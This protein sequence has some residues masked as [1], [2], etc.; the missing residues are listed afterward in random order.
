MSEKQRRLSR[1][2]KSGL[3]SPKSLKVYEKR[4]E[5]VIEERQVE[6]EKVNEDRLAGLLLEREILK[7]HLSGLLS[8]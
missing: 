2:K 3:V 1:A 8:D 5:E 4:L 7:I 6:R